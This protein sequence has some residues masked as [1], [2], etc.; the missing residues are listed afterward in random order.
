[1]ASKEDFTWTNKQQYQQSP[2]PIAASLVC[3][4]EDRLIANRE[5]FTWTNK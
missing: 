3:P 2:S 1:M 4:M 5:D